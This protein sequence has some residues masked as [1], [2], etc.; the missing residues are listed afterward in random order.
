MALRAVDDIGD[1]VFF[2]GNE[3]PYMP[4]YTPFPAFSMSPGLGDGNMAWPWTESYETEH[5]INKQARISK[6]F[7]DAA[8]EKI[9]EQKEWAKRIPKA[10]YFAS[11]VPVRQVAFAQAA[12]RP[13]LFEASLALPWY[14]IDPLNLDSEEMCKYFKYYSSTGSGTVQYFACC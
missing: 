6:N 8:F 2:F 1:S 5:E 14:P 10:A 7:S 13:D 11:F 9:T 3:W 12:I 4:W